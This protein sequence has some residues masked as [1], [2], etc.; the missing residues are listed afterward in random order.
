MEYPS[1]YTR[2]EFL[3]H[4]AGG[5]AGTV[6]LIGCG[7]SGRRW[8]FLTQEEG[9]L[10]EA[11]AAQIIPADEHPGAIEAG[12][13]DFID[14]QLVGPYK[15][16]QPDYREGLRGIEEVSRTRHRRSFR[17]ISAEAQADLLASLESGTADET[18]WAR[19]SG[20][21][22]FELVRSHSL[23]GFYG[24]PRH[25]GNRD[26]VSYRMLDLAVYRY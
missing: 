14:R 26:H 11:V 7:V 2:R 25:G 22:F 13:A 21:S 6:L 3:Q 16:F 20:A 10:L 9:L 19:Q 17:K 15:R 18:E 23:Q 1:P 8:E 4:A 24:D 12:V 5:V